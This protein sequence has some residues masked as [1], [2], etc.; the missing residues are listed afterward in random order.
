MN[1]HFL[2]FILGGGWK[3]DLARRSTRL[4]PQRSR[5]N[6]RSKRTLHTGKDLKGKPVS[7]TADG[8]GSISQTSENMGGLQIRA[9]KRG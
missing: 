1:F 3:G 9:K 4:K 5:G 2:S 6:I 7:E 8:Q